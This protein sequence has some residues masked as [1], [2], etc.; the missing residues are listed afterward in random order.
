MKTRKPTIAKRM[1]EC[2]NELELRRIFKQE[3][4]DPQLEKSL[5]DEIAR[6]YTPATR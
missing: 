4:K 6:Y 1:Q 5:R 3:G 2:K